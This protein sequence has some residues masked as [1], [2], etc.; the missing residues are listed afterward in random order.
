LLIFQL[1]EKEEDL[2]HI[3]VNFE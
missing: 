1:T 3:T 2:Q